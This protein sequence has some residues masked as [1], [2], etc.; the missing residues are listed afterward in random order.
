MERD[1]AERLASSGFDDITPARVHEIVQAFL[2][3]L[4]RCPYC[5]GS[6]VVTFNREVELDTT[7]GLGRD[8]D[9]RYIPAGTVGSC[10]C[11]GG[12][13]RDGGGR[14]DPSYVAWHCAHGLGSHDCE[15][16]RSVADAA[17]EL[18]GY[19]VV[20]PLASLPIS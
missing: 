11:C 6:G 13:D 14:Y 5:D 17:H 4:V 2:G 19:R 18:C 12:G 15:A 9:K 7:Q 20:L 1:L 10:P 16:A 3:E 8:V